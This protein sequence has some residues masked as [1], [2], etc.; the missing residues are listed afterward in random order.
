MY[1]LPKAGKP[2]LKKLGKGEL[3]VGS[4]AS[5]LV[6][7]SSSTASKLPSSDCRD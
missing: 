2:T 1:N 6:L 4:S 5:M 7:L 3:A